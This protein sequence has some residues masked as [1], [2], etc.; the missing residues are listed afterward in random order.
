MS[1]MQNSHSFATP[2]T[3]GTSW[4]RCSAVSVTFLIC[5][6][7]AFADEVW[8]TEEWGRIVYETDKGSIAIWSFSDQGAASLGNGKMFLEGLAG[9]WQNRATD[10]P[11]RGYWMVYDSHEA[12]CANTRTDAEG[13]TSSTHGAIEITFLDANFPTRWKAVWGLCDDPPDQTL[14]ATPHVG[15]N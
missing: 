7:P 6:S 9:V 2:R 3:R 14:N 10:R 11:Y 5:A 12:L 8:D 13:N 4:R 15:G 1:K